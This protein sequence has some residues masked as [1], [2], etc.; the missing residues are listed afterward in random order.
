MTKMTIKLL[1]KII[2]CLFNILFIG[3]LSMAQSKSDTINSVNGL[4]KV[5]R[6]KESSKTYLVYFTDSSKKIRRGVGEIWDR[7]VKKVK[8]NNTEMFQFD[9]KWISKDGIV[10]QTFGLYDA[11]TLAPV[12]YFAI[13]KM[14]NRT[15]TIA[16]KFENGFMVKDKKVSSNSVKEDFQLKMDIPV[17]NWE[18][19]LETYPLFP[20][21]KVGQIFEVAF[22]DVNEPKP[23]YHRYQVIGEDILEIIDNVKIPCW[24]L[25]IDYDAQNNATFWL[26]KKTGEMIKSEEKVALRKGF[27]Y[28]IKVRQF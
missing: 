26:S 12:N 7:T 6:L 2:I 25:K 11:K 1:K 14:P 17:L 18:L 28:S 13:N 3:Q 22:F 9:W 15:D 5:N 19:D 23:T 16:Y 20:I 8:L 27:M 21:K 10:K 24:L 4:L